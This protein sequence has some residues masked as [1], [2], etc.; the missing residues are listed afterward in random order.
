MYTMIATVYSNSC[1]S[2]RYTTVLLYTVLLLLYGGA[3]LEV[4][5]VEDGAETA[6]ATG[7]GFAL[8]QRW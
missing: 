4:D 6:V 8:T 5:T 3:W 7:A 2:T 1:G